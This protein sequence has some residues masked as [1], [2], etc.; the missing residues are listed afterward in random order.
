MPEAFDISQLPAAAQKILA[1]TAPK[2]A[3]MMAA[4]GIV[5]GLKPGDIVTVLA[6]L[7]EDEDTKI[8]EAALA[9]LAHLPPPI[10]N[11]ALG[12]PL[13]AFVVERF[14][15]D[16]TKNHDVIE[17]LLRQPAITLSA[18]EHL[19]DAAD[20]KAGELIA[21]N[22]ALMLK[23]P[24]V[25]EKLYMNERVR[26]STADR[27]LELAVR[28]GIEL[29]IP[30]YKEAA[31][32]IQ[33]ELI[34]EASE[35]PTYD[36]LLFEETGRI[37]RE[38]A[39]LEDD[40]THEIDEEGE[41]RVREA[42]RP[43]H[44]RIA[45]MTITQKIRRA[46]LGTAAERLILVRDPNR[47]VASAAAKSPRLQEPE[48]A[49]ITASRAVSDEVLRILALNR[50]FTRSYQIKLN[51]VSNPRTPFTFAS[52]LVPHL[53]EAD[54][55]KLAK[56]KNVTGAIAQAVKQQMTRKDSKR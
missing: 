8:G 13:P 20:E 37:A 14:A 7:G 53:R 42:F 3:K 25:I 22:E 33:N 43:L 36:D 19:A 48:V 16:Y 56:S 50:E 54:L 23:N 32:A 44:A 52:R 2:P 15:R 39:L 1:A 29:T 46:M 12:A 9:T 26:M 49:R 21:T 18:L 4:K 35:E 24:S 27:L 5:P 47:L 38:T 17:Q 10:L 55:K 30:A 11:G 34:P 6:L 51:L 45:D 31:T 40:D 28:N 41:E